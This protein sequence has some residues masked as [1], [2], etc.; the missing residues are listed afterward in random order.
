MV[1]Y[2]NLRTE[3]VWALTRRFYC[4]N[5]MTPVYYGGTCNTACELSCEPVQLCC[6]TITQRRL[7]DWIVSL[8]T[9]RFVSKTCCNTHR[10]VLLSLCSRR[11]IS[12]EAE[13]LRIIKTKH[14]RGMSYKKGA[15][16]FVRS[17]ETAWTPSWL[18]LPLVCTSHYIF[19]FWFR[20]GRARKFWK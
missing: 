18:F 11:L 6:R 10:L 7:L 16:L 1:S 12:F 17:S 9:V 2:R 20:N 5:A 8:I 14:W 4:S 15:R 13:V 19:F 3:V